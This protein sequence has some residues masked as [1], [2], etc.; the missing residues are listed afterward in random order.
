MLRNRPDVINQLRPL[1]GAHMSDLQ[2]A[3]SEPHIAVGIDG[4]MD[5]DEVLEMLLF[6]TCRGCEIC[7][8]GKREVLLQNVIS[9]ARQ[10]IGEAERLGKSDNDSGRY[11]S[12]LR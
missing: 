6:T 1:E 2:Q 9:A 5:Y 4:S 10:R 3:L 11:A 12:L 7:R 8:F